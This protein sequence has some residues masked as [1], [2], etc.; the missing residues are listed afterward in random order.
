MRDPTA[1][2]T[3]PVALEA[4]A[5]GGPDVLKDFGN[6]AARAAETISSFIILVDEK[7]FA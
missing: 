1:A 4:S 5:E 3:A 2:T 6:E 7:L